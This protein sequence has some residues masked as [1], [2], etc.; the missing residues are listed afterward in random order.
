MRTASGGGCT[1]S[2]AGPQTHLCEDPGEVYDILRRHY[3]RVGR[4][5][6]RRSPRHC[7]WP[8]STVRNQVRTT[9]EGKGASLDRQPRGE[10]PE[11]RYMA[12]QRRPEARLSGWRG[13]IGPSS[14]A[15]ETCEFVHGGTLVHGGGRRSREREKKTGGADD[16]GTSSG[17]PANRPEAPGEESAESPSSS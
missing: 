17:D 12:T 14:V 4:S 3:G 6:T 9:L 13:R 11:Q 2:A 7:R 1:E 16:A 5:L 15:F 10:R 8:L